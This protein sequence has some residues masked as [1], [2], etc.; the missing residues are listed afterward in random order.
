MSDATIGDMAHQV[1][2]RVKTANGTFQW[3]IA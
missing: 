2:A 1:Q 3:E